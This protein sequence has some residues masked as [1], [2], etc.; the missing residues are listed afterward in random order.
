MLSGVIEK[1]A[2]HC[3][4]LVYEYCYSI[5]FVY[6]FWCYPFFIKK[7][8]RVLRLGPWT[9]SFARNVNDPASPL[10][11]APMY[12]YEHPHART[13]AHMTY[14]AICICRRC[15]LPRSHHLVIL[16]SPSPLLHPSL[17]RCLI[18]VLLSRLKNI[19]DQCFDPTFQH[20]SILFSFLCTIASV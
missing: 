20:A 18:C 11:H 4:R 7:L 9:S 8:V 12:M 15:F 1:L 13:Y 19:F 5:D 10:A 2:K 16:R 6:A 14:Y 17:F 3:N